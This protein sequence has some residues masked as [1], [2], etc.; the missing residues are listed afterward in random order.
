MKNVQAERNPHDEWI[1]LGCSQESSAESE[2]LGPGCSSVIQREA[3][4]A[5]A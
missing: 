3:E 5:E 1:E 2:E 4:I